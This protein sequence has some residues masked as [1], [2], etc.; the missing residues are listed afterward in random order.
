[1][2]STSLEEKCREM[3]ELQNRYEALE[4]RLS[5][6]QEELDRAREAIQVIQREKQDQWTGSCLPADLKKWNIT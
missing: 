4:E 3:S 5:R 1:M 2:Q 6:K